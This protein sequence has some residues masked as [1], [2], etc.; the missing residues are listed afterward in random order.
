[1]QSVAPSRR[2]T[3]CITTSRSSVFQSRLRR[4]YSS[5]C[6]SAKGL[7][8]RVIY[9]ASGNRQSTWLPND[10]QARFN[11]E[12][13]G[14]RE[15]TDPAVHFGTHRDSL[16]LSSPYAVRDAILDRYHKEERKR[17]WSESDS[18]LVGLGG[19]SKTRR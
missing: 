4:C 9:H 6:K 7:A 5:V 14:S 1:M 15:V 19:Q 11:E 10:L 8:K 13:Y 17:T 16:E 18:L 3:P 2:S 12:V